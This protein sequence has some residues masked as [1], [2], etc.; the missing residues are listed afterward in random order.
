MQFFKPENYFAVR[1]ALRQ[2]GRQDLI[3]SGCDCLIP[4]APP[5]EALEARRKDVNARLRGGDVPAVSDGKKKG[6]RKASRH[7]P[8]QGYRPN[9]KSASDSAAPRKKKP[10]GRQSPDA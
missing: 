9:R 1:E 7:K 3:G 2:A 6:K 4:S 5:R 10:R 8:S